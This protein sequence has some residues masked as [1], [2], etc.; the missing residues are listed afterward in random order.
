MRKFAMIFLLFILGCQSVESERSLA[1]KA[2]TI[3]S[4]K[5]EAEQYPV[6]VDV[7]VPEQVGVNESFTMDAE[8]K[9]TS[10]EMLEITTGDPVFYYIIRDS[11]GKAINTVART[12]VGIVRTIDIKEVIVEK[13]S[14]RFKNPGIY[15]ISAVLELTIHNGDSR[16]VYKMETARKKIQA[17]ED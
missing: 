17:L 15:E 3:P 14:Y 16:K 8:I 1:D 12:D 9:N 6:A 10:D 7:I 13:H 4:S 11:T 2:E 5:A